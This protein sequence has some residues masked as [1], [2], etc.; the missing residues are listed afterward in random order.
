MAT[1]KVTKV[2]ISLKGGPYSGLSYKRSFGMRE[3]LAFTAN[4]L[5][6]LYRDGKWEPI[7]APVKIFEQGFIPFK[8][9][10]EL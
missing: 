2:S 8:K 7:A 1:K 6:G 5:Y 4:G 10:V 9:A 3:T